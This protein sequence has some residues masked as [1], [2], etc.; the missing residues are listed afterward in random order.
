MKK[1]M[2]TMAL[3]LGFFQAT[4]AQRQMSAQE[5]L[6]LAEKG[7]SMIRVEQ[8]RLEN[9]K[10]AVETAKAQR[11]PD[12]NAEV[13]ASLNG[14]VVMLDRNFGNANTFSQP[15]WGN[16]LNVEAQQII[17]AGGVINSSIRVAEL[18]EQMA[19]NNL[20]DTR[21]NVKYGALAQYLQILKLDNGIQVYSEN[22]RLTEQLLDHIKAKQQQGMALKNDVTRYELQLQNLNLG[23]RKLEDARSVVNYQLC[24]NLG[25]QNE[26]IIPEPGI[27]ENSYAKDGLDEW[28]SA[29]SQSS[30]ALKNIQIASQMAEEKITMAKSDLRP[31]VAMVAVDNLSGPYNYDIPPINNNFNICYLG[32]AVRYQIGNL[33]KSNHKIS[34][35]RTSLRELQETE[36]SVS[37]NVSNQVQ[38]AYTLYIQAFAELE[39]QQESVR[40]ASENYNVVSDRYANQLAL[41][42]DMLD[43]TNMKL[44]AELG[45]VDAKINIALAYYKLKLVSGSGF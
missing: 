15:R 38:E 5:L 25:I 1:K 14:N 24:N 11:L 35:A 17:Y 41:I 44:M 43:A 40:L 9:S 28:L 45:E 3:L 6:D 2:L 19:E 33:W 36:K 16:S 34:Q 13:S 42:T 37:E 8:T 18:A 32:V 26:R 39:T 30:I 23:K 21:N 31:K 29:S 20:L 10:N 27:I 22:I 7:N 12:L 4:N